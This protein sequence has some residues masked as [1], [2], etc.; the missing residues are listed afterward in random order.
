MAGD[1]DA[2]AA[3][4]E[5]DLTS[6]ELIARARELDAKATPG[7]WRACNHPPQGRHKKPCACGVVLAGDDMHIVPALGQ[8]HM[9]EWSEPGP[10]ARRNNTA[11]IA[12]SRTIIPALATALE[13]ALAKPTLQAIGRLAAERDA[14][15]ARAERMRDEAI[16]YVNAQ[17]PHMSDSWRQ[18][19][20]EAFDLEVDI[21]NHHRSVRRKVPHV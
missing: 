3:E 4:G 5:G 20:V 16:R 7:P 17:G 11:F 2:G 13:E 14:A 15:I 9:T 18:G 1:G 10:D 19:F 12:E 21:V 6:P 8:T